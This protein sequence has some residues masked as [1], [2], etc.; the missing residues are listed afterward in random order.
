MRRVKKNKK[1][2][3]IHCPL[4]RNSRVLK[5]LRAGWV[6]TRVL[7]EDK[8]LPAVVKL[9][10]TAGRTQAFLGYS[11]YRFLFMASQEMLHGR[12][13]PCAEESPGTETHKQL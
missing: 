6:R 12:S 5:Y 8:H 11:E 9:V 10:S 13:H 3:H 7:H 1:T 2:K 4:E